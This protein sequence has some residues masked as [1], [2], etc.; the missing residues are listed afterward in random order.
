MERYGKQINEGRLLKV[1][2][3]VHQIPDEEDT[4]LKEFTEKKFE[5]CWDRIEKIRLYKKGRN[6]KKNKE[7]LQKVHQAAKQPKASLVEPVLAAFG[8]GA[9]MGEIAGVMRLAYDYPYDPHGLLEP[10]I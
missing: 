8:D 7:V 10:P 4:M 2:A 3:N 9:T 1:G 5:P 6:Q